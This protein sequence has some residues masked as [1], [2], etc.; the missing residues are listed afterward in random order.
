[1]NDPLEE[2]AG[3]TADQLNELLGLVTSTDIAELDITL[4]STRLSLRRPA[5]TSVVQT[6][7]TQDLEEP[8]SLAIT[9][10][11]VGMF[12]PSVG[13]GALVELGQPIGAIEALGMPTSVDAPDSGI[14]EELLVQDGSPVEYGQPLLILRR[15]LQ[16][17]A[18]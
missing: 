1:M 13:V 12:R 3:V 10:P 15:A 5:H 17:H 2:H 16:T 7:Q 14:V 8:S 6:N 18:T 4:G 11:L 9:S